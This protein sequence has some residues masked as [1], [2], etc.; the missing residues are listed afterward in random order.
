MVHGGPTAA[1]SSSL[2]PGIQ[3]YTTR[4][5]AVLDVNYA[6]ST[7]YGRPYRERLYGEWGIADVDDCCA[8]ARH[9]A[10]RG[11]VD[12]RRLAITGGSAGGYTVLSALT[13]RDV[14]AA[15]ASHFG[16]SD[17]ELL[18][19]ETH[20]FE[21]RYLDKLIGPYPEA[22]DLYVQRS[23]IHHLSRLDCPVIF[24]QGLEDP[25]VPAN[26]A[27]TMADALR[28]RDVPVALME[29][30]GEQH[31]FR[32]AENIR[33]ALEAELYFFSRIFQF[34]PAD[35]IEPVEIDNLED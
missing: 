15:G 22:R 20:K 3:Y 27:R 13:F 6:G 2:R 12:G 29:F 19:T 9:M 4:G 32:R 34:A 17:C 31:G 11:R 5:V 33:R 21:A 28:E 7:G 35:Q 18:A 14:F 1:T 30:E 16:V 26:Q 8:G 23:P 25:I 24:F 10:E